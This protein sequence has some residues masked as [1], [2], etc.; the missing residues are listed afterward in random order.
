M[1]EDKKHKEKDKKGKFMINIIIISLI[2]LNAF[3]ILMLFKML[4]GTETQFK[5]I[6]AG[7]LIIVNLIIVNIIYAIGKIGIAQ[8]VAQKAKP[9]ILFTILPINLIL[10]ASPIA[11]QLSKARNGDIEKDKFAK[12]IIIFIII[13]I[14]IIC[15]ECAY[16]KNIQLGIE[17]MGRGI[18]DNT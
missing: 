5:I 6:S 17:E 15:L 14:V 10:M 9:L 11:V 2:I 13:D 4:K 1:Q 18:N 3:A 12:N 8:E 16:I 7:I